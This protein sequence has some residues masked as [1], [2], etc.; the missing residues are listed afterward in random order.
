M[1]DLAFDGIMLALLAFLFFLLLEK[2]T[3]RKP[4]VPVARPQPILVPVP[5]TP[6]P[7]PE[8]PRRPGPKPC[9]GPGPCPREAIEAS[10]GGNTA[11][12]G[13]PIQCDLPGDLHLKNI[14]GRDGAGLC[15]FT[16]LAHAARWQ[17]V[18]LL[19]DFRDWMRQYPG[20]GYPSKVEKMITKKAQESGQPEPEY[21]QIEGTDLEMLRMACRTGRMPCVTYS[22]SPTKRYGGARIAHM[23]NLVHADDKGNFGV[24]DNNYPG[25]DKIEWMSEAEFKKTYTGGRQGWSVILLS[26]P[27]PPVPRN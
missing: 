6:T 21:V 7:A 13:T 8:P 11:P 23:V 17:A 3:A 16:S 1:R 22:F 25:A 18:R 4:P 5:V 10:V 20:G 24:L 14:G 2:G 12:D 15:V 9:P 26:P 19:E 27:P